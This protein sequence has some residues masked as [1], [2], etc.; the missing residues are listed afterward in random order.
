MGLQLVRPSIAELRELI[1]AQ[2]MPVRE[3]SAFS[4]FPEGFPKRT[5]IEM[6]G[7]GKT[8][9]VAL[10]LKEH[11]EFKVAWVESRITIN[12]Y[13]LRQMGVELKNILFVESGEEP[14]GVLL[15]YC[16][17]A[18]FKRSSPRIVNS[19]NRT[20]VAFSF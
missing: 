19:S 15:R 2:E 14:V 3:K 17:R 7:V 5:L 11:P 10:F 16:S 8:E 9:L 13:A 1:G 12:P 18:A 20:Y 6:A 4:L